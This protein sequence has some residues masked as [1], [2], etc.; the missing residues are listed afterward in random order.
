MKKPQWE[1]DNNITADRFKEHHKY[2]CQ[3]AHVMGIDWPKDKDKFMGHNINYW[4]KLY[5]KDEHLNNHPL[6]FF[7][8]LHYLRV[9]EKR[10]P[11]SMS[12][13]VCCLK[14]IIIKRVLEAIE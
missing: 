3:L 9:N 6:Y 8:N 12:D 5:K 11:W 4:I 7:D 10:I 14:N 2:Y 13:T 1:I